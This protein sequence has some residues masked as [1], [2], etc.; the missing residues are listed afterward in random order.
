[1]LQIFLR[2]EFYSRKSSLSFHIKVCYCSSNN[3]LL[4]RYTETGVSSYAIGNYNTF[5]HVPIKKHHD[6]VPETIK[7][8]RVAL[9]RAIHMSW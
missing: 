5:I 8:L 1:M 7:F 9:N 2:L 6:F 3:R 4:F